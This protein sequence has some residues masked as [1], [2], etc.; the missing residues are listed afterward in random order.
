VLSYI[1]LFLMVTKSVVSKYIF[2]TTLLSNKP[3]L[4][5]VTPCAQTTLNRAEYIGPIRLAIWPG[6]IWRCLFLFHALSFSFFRFLSIF[7]FQVFLWLGRRSTAEWRQC[8]TANGACTGCPVAGASVGRCPSQVISP[9]AF[10]FCPISD[11]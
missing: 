5:M 4:P 2:C 7:F 6:G 1:S 8:I 11:F 3:C 10:C 9:S